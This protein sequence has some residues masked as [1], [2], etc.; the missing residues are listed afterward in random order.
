M[1]WSSSSK[2]Q[3]CAFK[4]NQTHL[5]N[6]CFAFLIQMKRVQNVIIHLRRTTAIVK[7]KKFPLPGVTASRKQY[8]K[9]TCHSS[10]SSAIAWIP[11]HFSFEDYSCT[12]PQALFHW[13]LHGH[14]CLCANPDIRASRSSSTDCKE[15]FCLIAWT[16]QTRL[17]RRTWRIVETLDLDPGPLRVRRSG[18]KGQTND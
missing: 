1:N 11:S 5:G 18:P 13:A 8:S 2:D 3:C 15:S 16:E 10:P 7:K 17:L 9:Q 6:E 12:D 14:A 4:N